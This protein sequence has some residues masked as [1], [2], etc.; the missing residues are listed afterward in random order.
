MTAGDQERGEEKEKIEGKRRR[1]GGE[2]GGRAVEVMARLF[3]IIM[4]GHIIL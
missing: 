2:R 1:E 4:C 3:Q